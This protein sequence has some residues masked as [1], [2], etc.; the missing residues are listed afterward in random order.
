VRLSAALGS[1][2]LM[3][4]SHRAAAAVKT[5]ARAGRTLVPR[6][7]V[8][9]NV[10]ALAALMV[11]GVVA[12]IDP[13]G[14]LTFSPTLVTP[15]VL[16]VAVR[17]DADVHGL[18]VWSYVPSPFR[19]RA[20]VIARPAGSEIVHSNAVVVGAD[21][22]GVTAAKALITGG[23]VSVFTGGGGVQ[24]VSAASVA[25]ASSSSSRFIASPKPVRTH[26]AGA[27][28]TLGDRT[29]PVGLCMFNTSIVG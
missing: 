24:A 22:V 9:V 8:I 3:T 10:S 5:D 2:V 20:H 25:T 13:T 1:P 12:E 19:S 28:E 18:T 23:R 4:A 15:T 26:R 14:S 27:C 16:K 17:R 21:P 7:N 11:T 29:L 6:R